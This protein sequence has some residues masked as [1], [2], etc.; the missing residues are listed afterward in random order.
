[1]VPTVT[2]VWCRPEEGDGLGRRERREGNPQQGSRGGGG[3]VSRTFKQKR[4]LGRRTHRVG[5]C[6]P[7][8]CYGSVWGLNFTEC[9]VGTVHEGPTSNN[10]GTCH[11]YRIGKVSRPGVMSGT[12][13]LVP[14]RAGYSSPIVAYPSL[15]LFSRVPRSRPTITDNPMFRSYCLSTKDSEFGLSDSLLTDDLTLQL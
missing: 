5:R 8:I 3:A 15:I 14:V 12:S 4:S 6:H 10:Q 1:M 11:W 9:S 7:Q 2:L 13:C